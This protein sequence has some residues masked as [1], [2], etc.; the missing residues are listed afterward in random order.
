MQ[1]ISR[2]GVLKHEITEVYKL[3]ALELDSWS[4]VRESPLVDSL[5]P[6]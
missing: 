3:Q 4:C 5:P 1:S 2:L 6:H